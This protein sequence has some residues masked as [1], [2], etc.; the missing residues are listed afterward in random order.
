MSTLAEIRAARR[1]QV[2]PASEAVA[3][4]LDQHRAPEVAPDPTPRCP[5]CRAAVVV[6]R[7]DVGALEHLDAD[8]VELVDY[9]ALSLAGADAAIEDHERV[10]GWRVTGDRARAVPAVRV[11][12]AALPGVPR[13][14]LRRHHQTTCTQADRHRRPAERR[15]HADDE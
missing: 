1:A 2:A 11:S 7:S 9:T 3:E 4:H 8:E 13:T 15:T 10:T 12:P 14:R 6:V 5:R